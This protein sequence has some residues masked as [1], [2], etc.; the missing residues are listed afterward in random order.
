[1]NERVTIEICVGDLESALAAGDGGADR[2]ELCDNLAVG[3]T[4]PSAGTIAEA[5]RRLRIPVHVLIRPR[6]GDFL[7]TAAE[8]A[9]MRHDIE[10][11]RSLGASGVVLGLLCPDGTVDRE[12]TARLVELARPLS[13]TFHKAFDQVRDPA[14]ALEALIALGVDRVLTSGCRPT[15]LEGSDA[16]RNLADQARGRIAILAGGRLSAENIETILSRAGVRE[17]HLGSAVTRLM[18]SAMTHSPNDGSE[19]TWSGV[20]P[21]K[22]REIVELV[23]RLG[24]SRNG[25]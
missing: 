11:A 17:I 24:R 5:C 8:L 2:V 6:A 22:V 9:A 18:Q 13:V 19:L 20:D 23:C 7:P 14:E 4:T 12:R 1:M 15:A 16:L 3:G 21:Q 25:Y 10:L